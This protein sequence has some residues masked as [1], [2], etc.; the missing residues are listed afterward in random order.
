[1]TTTSVT[2]NGARV[3]EGIVHVP[4]RGPWWADLVLETSD[5]VSGS[6]TIVAGELTLVGTVVDAQSGVFALQRKVRVVAG[7]DGW[8]SMLSPRAYHSDGQVQALVV[9]QDA[10]RDVGETL[11]SFV[12]ESATLGVDF[13]RE[14][15]TAATIL[16]AA[17]GSATWWVGFD[18]VTVV[19]ERTTSTPAAGSYELLSWDPSQRIAELHA[20]DVSSIAIGSVLAADE[21]MADAQTVRAIDLVIGEVITVKAWCGDGPGARSRVARALEAIVER[22]LARRLLVPLI[23]RVIAMSGDR[24]MLQAVS[25]GAPDLSP[26]SLAP[27]MAGLHAELAPGALVQVS[28]AEG[29]RTRPRIVA[30]EGKDGAGWSPTTLT[31]GATAA[32]KVGANATLEAARRTDGVRVTIPAGTVIVAASGG[33]LNPSPIVLTGDIT[34][35]S[36][37]VQVE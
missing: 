5:D 31:L 18:G 2:V 14:A 1:M 35:G 21:R 11:G 20:D 32:I 26:I 30:H 37:K 12:P 13:V 17:I 19:G 34:G 27:G 7:A 29:D 9:A 8:R 6:A 16:E 28:F 10:A 22:V 36:A 23:Y 33:T 25:D 3:V 4:S 24:V 15:T